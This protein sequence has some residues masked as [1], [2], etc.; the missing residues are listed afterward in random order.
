MPPVA[1][2]IKQE[3][4]QISRLIAVL[5]NEQDILKRGEVGSLPETTAQKSELV[6][7]LNALE[8][9]R[10]N[11]LD[12][13]DDA[14][15]RGAMEKWLLRHPDDL[16]AASWKQLLDLA[17]EAKVLHEL[18]GQ[19]VHQHLRQTSEALSILTQQFDKPTLYGSS[20]Q[21]LQ[22]TGSRLVDSA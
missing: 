5:N 15:G 19:L 11:A 2:I 12:P 7:K 6:E 8:R 16:T 3:I 4:E 18:N 10:L 20:G 14:Q 17:R 13:A 1:A 21:T 22:A 9:E